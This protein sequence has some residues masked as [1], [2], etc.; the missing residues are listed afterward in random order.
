MILKTTL[1]AMA[2][3]LA[4][5]VSAPAMALEVKPGLNKHVLDSYRQAGKNITLLRHKVL[6]QRRSL[7]VRPASIRVRLPRR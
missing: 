3:A 5:T 6:T 2:A 4:L 7:D 1:L